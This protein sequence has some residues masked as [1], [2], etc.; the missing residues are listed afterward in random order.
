[1]SPPGYQAPV[2]RAM[3]GKKGLAG[4]NGKEGK[5]KKL[6]LTKATDQVY[7]KHVHVL[8]ESPNPD[9]TEM[10]QVLVAKNAI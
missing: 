2:K 7:G 8:K 10:S 3:R 6:N 5:R 4:G 9:A 1:M